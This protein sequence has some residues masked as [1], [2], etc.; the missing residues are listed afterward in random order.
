MH[1]A[2]ISAAKKDWYETSLNQQGNLLT[3]DVDP[4]EFEK[5]FNQD[6]KAENRTSVERVVFPNLPREV[7]FK[8]AKAAAIEGIL[9]DQNGFALI[10]QE[11]ILMG[12]EL[13]PGSSVL[14][15][16]QTDRNG[17]FQFAD[18]PT[19][20]FWRFRLPVGA[21]RDDVSSRPFVLLNAG[22]QH[23]DVVL[24]SQPSDVKTVTFK[25]SNR[26]AVEE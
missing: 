1:A 20:R 21:T 7:N 22:L 3:S 11:I 26:T 14:C 18:V 25:L 24:N 9:V 10:D 13:P 2:L 15:S 6:V 12:N 4:R 8:L 17:K 16:I 23:F 5:L 19:H